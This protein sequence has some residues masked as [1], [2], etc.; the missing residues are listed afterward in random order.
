MDLGGLAGFRMM[1][2]PNGF[3]LYLSRM[4]DLETLA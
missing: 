3:D 2:R 1:L 4:I